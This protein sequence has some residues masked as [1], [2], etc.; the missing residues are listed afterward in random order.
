[1]IILKL[2][3]LIRDMV[4]WVKVHVSLS[5]QKIWK[6]KKNKDYLWSKLKPS[7]IFCGEGGASR[8]WTLVVPLGAG[9]LTTKL[10]VEE[11]LFQ[12]FA[13][14]NKINYLL[15]VTLKIQSNNFFMTDC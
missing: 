4:V 7:L 3:Q 14:Q 1:M 15:K 6:I 8:N 9:C 2:T 10:P 13:H 11:H 12:L 5:K